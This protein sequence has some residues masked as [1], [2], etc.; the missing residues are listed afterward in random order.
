MGLDSL[1]SRHD[2]PACDR[3]E[4]PWLEGER[5][6]HTAVLCGRNAVQ[7]SPPGKFS[8]SL[9]ELERKLEGAGEVSRNRFLLRLAVDGYVLTVFPNGR[10]IIGGTDDVT[11]AR[12]VYAKYIGS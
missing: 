6:S 2:C 11:T 8:L 3:R 4:F 10:A 7:L 9:E 12:S 1:G 5:G